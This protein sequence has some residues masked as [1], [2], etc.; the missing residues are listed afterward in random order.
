MEAELKSLAN[1]MSS[2]EAKKLEKLLTEEV[3]NLREKLTS[4]KETTVKVEPEEKKKITK[5]NEKITTEYRK[6]KRICMDIANTILENYP[7]P[8]KTFFE[9][10]GIE[11]DEDVAR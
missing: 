4:L 6:R 5:E 9:E 11:T 3:G 1:K 8:K 2:D 10:V 7:K